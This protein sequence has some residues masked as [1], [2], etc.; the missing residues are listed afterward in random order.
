M[1]EMVD[2]GNV[3]SDLAAA[4]IEREARFKETYRLWMTEAPQRILLRASQLTADQLQD[5][6]LLLT[7]EGYRD[8]YEYIVEQHAAAG[9]AARAKTG[10]FLRKGVDMQAQAGERNRQLVKQAAEQLI[11]SRARPYSSI[12]QLAEDVVERTGLS[13]STVR[14]H[15]AAL[16]MRVN[17]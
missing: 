10:T 4:R 8:L 3:F 16:G 12:S 14:G 13:K 9:A 17:R 2:S 15:L 7:L 1:V 11:R 6:L 5:F